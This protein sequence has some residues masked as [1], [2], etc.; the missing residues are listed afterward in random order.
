M[1]GYRIVNIYVI[2]RW[3]VDNKQ[4]VWSIVLMPWLCPEVS[5]EKSMLTFQSGKEKY[6]DISKVYYLSCMKT[7]DNFKDKD[8]PVSRKL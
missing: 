7:I 5:E 2:V 6:A 3:H 8:C 4:T 1:G